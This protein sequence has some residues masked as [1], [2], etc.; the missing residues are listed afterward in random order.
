MDVIIALISILIKFKQETLANHILD[1][2]FI[3]VFTTKSAVTV[4]FIFFK[5]RAASTII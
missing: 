2:L 5:K 3:F 1:S 4:T